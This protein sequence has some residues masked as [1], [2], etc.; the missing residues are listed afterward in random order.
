MALTQVL[1]Y[2]MSDSSLTSYPAAADVYLCPIWFLPYVLSGWL[3]MSCL[4][5][6]RQSAISHHSPVSWPLF[7][8]FYTQTFLSMF[9]LLVWTFGPMNMHNKPASL[10]WICYCPAFRQLFLVCTCH[11]FGFVAFCSCKINFL[12]VLH[13]SQYE[14]IIPVKPVDP[15]ASDHCNRIAG[16][17]QKE[18]GFSVSPCS[19]SVSLLWC[20]IPLEDH[21]QSLFLDSS[22]AIFKYAFKKRKRAR[23]FFSWCVL[24]EAR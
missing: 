8:L 5:F 18:S 2:S 11:I 24:S 14:M 4:I 13:P 6:T 15:A 23:S 16:K 12:R 3:L 22:N 7:F 19:L 1:F 10:T 20:S 17:T 21:R 9:S